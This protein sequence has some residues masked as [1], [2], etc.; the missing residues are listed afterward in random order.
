MWSFTKSKPKAAAEPS[1][2]D[3]LLDA[4]RAVAVTIQGAEREAERLVDEA[5][6]AARAAD[7]QAERELAETLNLLDERAVAQCAQDALVIE[8]EASRRAQLFAEAD[9]VHIA[10]IAERLALFVAPVA[11]AP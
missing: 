2:L 8:T 6:A 3:A 10:A 5:R 1:A 7:E 11:N 9:A 4:E